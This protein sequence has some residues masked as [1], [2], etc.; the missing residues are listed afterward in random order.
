MKTQ[1]TDFNSNHFDLVRVD[2][3]PNQ[4]QNAKRLTDIDEGT[5]LC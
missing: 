3:R 2:Q 5:T 1:T 4:K